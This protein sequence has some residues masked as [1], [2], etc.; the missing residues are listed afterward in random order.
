MSK[1][2][3]IQKIKNMINSMQQEVHQFRME[4]SEVLPEKL[5][6][7]RSAESQESASHTKT[8][9]GEHSRQRKV[10]SSQRRE[11]ATVA[12]AVSVDR[13]VGDGARQA[14]LWRPQPLR[15]IL[16]TQEAMR[17]LFREQCGLIRIF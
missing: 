1:H 4:S 13:A 5:I 11:W 2:L 17:G 10:R 15:S 3:K 12:G 7:E 9:S 6:L 14:G 16:T 8:G